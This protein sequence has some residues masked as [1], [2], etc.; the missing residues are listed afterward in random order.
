M[1]KLIAVMIAACA[2]YAHAQ[3]PTIFGSLQDAFDWRG[4]NSLMNANEA[5]IS[6][7]F[8]WD[9]KNQDAGAAAKLDWWIS[10]QQGAYFG[11]EEYANGRT[12]YWSVGY[13]ARTVF[14]GFECSLGTGIRQNTDQQFGDVQMIV[15]PTITKRIFHNDNWDIRLAGG[16]DVPFDGSKPNPF[17]G[18]TF[19]AFR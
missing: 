9:T 17:F 6:T 18:I 8:K 4:T 2:F 14:K 16:C 11:Y 7:L 1:K 5:N 12:A 15:T 3:T 10:N 13:Q 19:R